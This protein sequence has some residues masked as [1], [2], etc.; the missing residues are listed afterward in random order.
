[1]SSLTA[2]LHPP[3]PFPLPLQTFAVTATKKDTALEMALKSTY[4]APKYTIVSTVSQAG[5][6]RRAGCIDSQERSWD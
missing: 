3:F 6:V 1:M 2:C 5:K 4:T